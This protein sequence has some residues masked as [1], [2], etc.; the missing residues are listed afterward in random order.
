M[1]GLT[2][3]LGDVKMLALEAEERSRQEAHRVT[4]LINFARG[5]QWQQEGAPAWFRSIEQDPDAERARL[6]IVRRLISAYSSMVVGSFGGFAVSP[7]NPSSAAA[8]QAMMT[9]R[10]VSS[11]WRDD[12]YF[13]MDARAQAV[14]LGAVTGA[15]WVKVVYDPAKN[16]ERGGRVDGDIDVQVKTRNEVHPDPSARRE[17]DITYIFET[18]VIP[19]S[20]A[21]TRYPTTFYGHPTRPEMFDRHTADDVHMNDWAIDE[22]DHVLGQ[23][24]NSTRN[25]QV[26]I[27]KCWWKPGRQFPNGLFVAYT[28]ETMLSMGPLPFDFPWVMFRGPYPVPWSLYPDGMLMDLEHP[29]RDA[30][31]IAGRILEWI[32]RCSAPTILAHTESNVSEDEFTDMAG[33]VV[34]YS[35]NKPAPTWMNPPTIPGQLFA[36]VDGRMDLMKTIAAISEINLGS[37]P[38]D[39]FS[40]RAVAILEDLQ[41]SSHGEAFSSYHR[42]C[43]RVVEKM[44]RIARDFWP[45]NKILK[46]SDAGA[47]GQ[48]V[49]RRAEFDSDSELVVQVT[50]GPKS[51]MAARAEV[52]EMYM[53]GV[54]QDTPDAS[55][56]RAEL[57]LAGP[58]SESTEQIHREKALRENVALFEAGHRPEVDV[59]DDHEV[60]WRVHERALFTESD[61]ARR[62]MLAEHLLEHRSYL[63]PA[64]QDAGAEGGG[65]GGLLPPDEATLPGGDQPGAESPMNGGIGDLEAMGA[66]GQQP[67]PK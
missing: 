64:A 56:A 42:S 20:L 13:P 28:G 15:S 16:R 43:M 33:G 24:G 26:K 65:G 48:A 60:H 3:F 12:G 59:L 67:G 5:F 47:Q 51:R 7:S 17:E 29:Q 14:F 50:S 2:D 58:E 25:Y 36:V 55:R 52:L 19:L 46:T 40:G 61:I 32:K 1:A 18:E 37:V 10:V 66:T 34:K 4:E 22:R 30:N 49:F 62:R 54:Y 41:R 39:D 11:L 27:T 38:T 8:L 23:T 6:N 9:E 31:E 63:E 45:D 21:L 57:R 44:M 35:G 53:A